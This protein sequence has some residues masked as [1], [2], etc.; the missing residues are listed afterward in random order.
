MAVAARAGS[1][2]GCWKVPSRTSEDGSKLTLRRS[3]RGAVLRDF[4]HE[5]DKLFEK[6]I[7]V[8]YFAR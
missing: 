2:H 4:L 3:S 8:L 6:I 5:P 1:I 7:E